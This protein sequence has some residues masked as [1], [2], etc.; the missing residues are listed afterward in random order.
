M[1]QLCTREVYTIKP[2]SMT[3]SKTLFAD[4]WCVKSQSVLDMAIDNRLYAVAPFEENPL[5][6]VEG[7]CIVNFNKYYVRVQG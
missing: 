7:D 3:F 5:N 6:A 1:V 2:E 4:N